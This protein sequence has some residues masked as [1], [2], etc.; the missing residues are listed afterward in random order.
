VLL[1]VLRNSGWLLAEKAVRLVVGLFVSGWTARY[2]GLEQFGVLSYALALVAMFAVIANLG[3]DSIVVRDLARDPARA[4]ETLGSAS[5]LKAAG[6]ALA[7][8]A[9]I[10]AALLSGADER[11]PWLVA[12]AAP[13]LLAQAFDTVDLWF[14]SQLQVRYPVIARHAAFLA[15]AALKVVLILSAAPLAAFAAA[16]LAESLLAAACLAASYRLRRRSFRDWSA[17]MPRMR[18]LLA[19]CWPLL[20]SALAIATYMRLAQVLLGELSGSAAVGVYSAAVTLSELWYAVPAAVA[21]SVAPLVAQSRA[22]NALAYRGQLV[23]LLRG[24]AVASVAFALAVTL[25]AEPLAVF[26]FGAAFRD[27]GPLLAVHVWSGVF[28]ALGVAS[29]QYLVNENLMKVA[30]QRTLAG[31]AASVA[32]NLAW[33]PHFGALGAAW[34]SVVACAIATLFL[35]HSPESRGCL[36]LIWAALVPLA[37]RTA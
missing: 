30:L 21:A 5:L 1:T 25:L 12:L 35:F 28:V 9:C 18:A 7:T 3:L 11:L 4:G 23:L 29:S 27:A 24:L 33:I 15:V 8:A 26:V 32:L 13:G 36:R 2:L 31:A 22:A 17:S 34:A 19:Q 16:A 37:R 20:L 6:A 10:A 14:Q